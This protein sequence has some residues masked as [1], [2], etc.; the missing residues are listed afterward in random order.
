MAV[1]AIYRVEIH[2][3]VLESRSLK[4]LLSRAV[5]EKRSM[6]ARFRLLLRAGAGWRPGAPGLRIGDCRETLPGSA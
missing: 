6:D 4:L 5:A 2:G 1:A 3:Q